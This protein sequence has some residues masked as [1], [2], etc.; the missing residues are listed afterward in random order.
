MKFESSIYVSSSV[1][2]FTFLCPV[3][4]KS[5]SICKASQYHTPE[6]GYFL[7]ILAL[8]PENAV[9]ISTAKRNTRF[10]FI[11]NALRLLFPY[12]LPSDENPYIGPANFFSNQNGSPATFGKKQNLFFPTPNYSACQFANNRVSRN[13]SPSPNT[14]NAETAKSHSW[15]HSASVYQPSKE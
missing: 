8:H 14:G 12:F 15:I 7:T 13:S 1:Y 2:S 11:F 10:L 5:I 4:E 6:S 9:T 3:F